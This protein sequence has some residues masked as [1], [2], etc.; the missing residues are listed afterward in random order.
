VSEDVSFDKQLA[1]PPHSSPLQQMEYWPSASFSAFCYRRLLSHFWMLWWYHRI[2]NPLPLLL[3][4]DRLLAHH[5]WSYLLEDAAAAS[6]TFLLFGGV[7]S[8]TVLVL[9]VFTLAYT[10]EYKFI[11]GTTIHLY[12][13]KFK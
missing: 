10:N 6:S 13:S 7:G 9:L 11:D 1:F 5:S 4:Y 12:H 3:K 8:D 2:F